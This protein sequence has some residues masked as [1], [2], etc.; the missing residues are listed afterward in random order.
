MSDYNGRFVV[1]RA[2][3]SYFERAEA[4]LQQLE[5]DNVC[6]GEKVGGG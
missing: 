4:E 2:F 6:E 5:V 1:R 3:V